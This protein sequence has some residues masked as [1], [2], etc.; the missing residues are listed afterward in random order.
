MAYVRGPRPALV[1]FLIAGL[2]AACG[3]P[4]AAVATR[5]DPSVALRAAIERRI[6]A[7]PAGRERVAAE[8]ERAVVGMKG[9]TGREDWNVRLAA[10][11]A[12][13][14]E[15]LSEKQAA[16]DA[17]AEAQV[18][19]AFGRHLSMTHDYAAADVQFDWVLEHAQNSPDA[20]AAL[21]EKAGNRWRAKR[22]AASKALLE[23]V[24]RDYPGTPEADRARP[25]IRNC[26]QKLENAK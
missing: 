21:T 1:A 8:I 5:P 2:A 4:P 13:L 20:P 12:A 9:V 10:A 19:V 17:A 15:L 3:E 6:E 22:Y 23:R 25:G 18:R 16:G 24:V 7:L 11:V 26:E 14:H